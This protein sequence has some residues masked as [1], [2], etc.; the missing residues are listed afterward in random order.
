MDEYINGVDILN[1]LLKLLSVAAFLLAAVNFSRT[2]KVQLAYNIIPSMYIV[3]KEPYT[4]ISKELQISYTGIERSAILETLVVI[5]NSG[6]CSIEKDNIRSPLKIV[7]PKDSSIIDLKILHNG[8][9]DHINF[10]PTYEHNI[11]NIIFNCINEQE[12]VILKIVHT[13]YVELNDIK[14][15]GF[16]VVAG[17]KGVMKDYNKYPLIMRF[18]DMIRHKLIKER[19]PRRL[20]FFGLGLTLLVLL[21]HPYSSRWDDLCTVFKT[22]VPL[23]LIYFLLLSSY[24]LAYCRLRKAPG[25]LVKKTFKLITKRFNKQPKHVRNIFNKVDFSS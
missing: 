24:Y 4:N 21:L 9:Q 13:E 1:L 7:F 5:W 3:N 10:S 11:V 6:N 17:K 23:Y 14:S 25:E 2:N 20:Q 19:L 16:Y 8:E 22:L 15:E 18:T 12:G